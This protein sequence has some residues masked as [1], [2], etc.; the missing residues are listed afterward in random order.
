MRLADKVKL[1]VSTAFFRLFKKDARGESMA[2]TTPERGKI[3]SFTPNLIDGQ[4]RPLSEYRGHVLLIVNVASKCGFTPQ[5][6]GLQKLHE[7]YREKGLRV[8]AFPANEFGAQ[9]PGAD[10]EIQ[11][12][13]RKNYGVSFDVFSKIKVK[14]PG[15][16]PL[17]QFLTAESRFPGAIPWNF[18]KFLV[19]REG[20]VAGRFDPDVDPLAKS[21]VKKIEDLLAA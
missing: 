17:Y 15:Q 2:E 21:F 3:Y 13:C 6:E 1:S 4:P 12:F 9:E 10:A 11:A 20:F 16:H 18:T 19:D 8:L 7:Q 5:Y 14:G